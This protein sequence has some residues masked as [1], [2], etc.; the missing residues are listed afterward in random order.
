MRSPVENR[1]HTSAPTRY[2]TTCS[3][4]NFVNLQSASAYNSI[5]KIKEGLQVLVFEKG[6]I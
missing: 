6:D 4:R 3:K 2:R 5:Q 1:F